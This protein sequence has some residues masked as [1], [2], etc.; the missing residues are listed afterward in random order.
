[1][2]N[3]LEWKEIEERNNKLNEKRMNSPTLRDPSETTKE[4]SSFTE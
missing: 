1:M 4:E 3:T 2:V